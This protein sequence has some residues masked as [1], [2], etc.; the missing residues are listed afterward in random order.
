MSKTWVPFPLFLKLDSLWLVLTMVSLSRLVSLSLPTCLLPLSLSR[1]PGLPIRCYCSG[2]CPLEQGSNGTCWTKPGGYCYAS[3]QEVITPEKKFEREWSYGCLPPEE[4]GYMQCQG[5]LSPHTIPRSIKCCSFGDLC[6]IHLKPSYVSNSESKYG[7]GHSFKDPYDSDWNF[8][9]P[10]LLMIILPTTLLIVGLVALILTLFQRFRPSKKSNT[11]SLSM[12][13]SDSN[14]SLNSDHHKN[15]YGGDSI[16]DITNSSGAGVPQLVQRT[17]ASEINFIKYIG[18]GRFGQVFHASWRGD[19]V[20]VKMF[21]TTEE[22]SWR[23]EHD[24]FNTILLR[25]ENILGFI[26]S[27]IRGTGGQTQMLLITEYHPNGSLFD[28]LTSHVVDEYEALKLMYTSLCGL[29]HLHQDINPERSRWNSGITDSE[30]KP[31]IAHRDIKSKNILVKG[32]GTCCIADFGLCVLYET[33]W[34]SPD[35]PEPRE[36]GNIRVG[37]KRYMAPEVLDT[38]IRTDD[39]ESFKRSDIYSFSLVLW[40]ILRRTSTDHGKQLVES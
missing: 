30:K 21:K 31:A 9:L 5:Y 10:H 14:V 12:I 8:D 32:D 7:S 25:H 16:K 22:A 28:F 38:S 23:R 17:I 33:K 26:A 2:H 6:N 39:F 20:A 24:I 4:T 15:M 18:G 11:S 3:V 19:D 1:W 27:D 40:E 34:G 35:I 36:C 29:C 37:T 13:D